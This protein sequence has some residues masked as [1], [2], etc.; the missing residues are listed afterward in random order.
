MGI[1]YVITVIAMYVAFILLK[2]S[3][4]K[5]N[6]ISFGILGG[7]AYLAYNILIC[8][9]FGALNVTTNLVFLSIANLIVAAGLGFKIFKDKEIQK[10]EIRKRDI[11]AV[12]ICI[13][14]V[15][16]MAVSQY[17]PL[18]KTVANASVDANANIA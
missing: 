11:L 13:I 1:F 4:T 8:M 6:L 5:Q 18:S 9:V 12:L 16:Y 14:I 3:E 7:I 15:C 17:T 2:K 10:Y